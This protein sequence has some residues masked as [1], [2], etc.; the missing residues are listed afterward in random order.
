MW[1]NSSE[2]YGLVAII[3]HWLMALVIIGMFALGL[4]MVSLDYYDDWYHRGPFIHKSIGILLALVLSLRLV[5]RLNNGTPAAIDSHSTLVKRFS[6]SAHWLL[7]ILLFALVLSGY[8]ISTA[9]GKGISVFDWFEVPATIANIEGQADIAAEL[10]EWFAWILIII[11]SI[12]ALAALKHHFLD[13][14][15]TLKRMLVPTKK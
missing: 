4:W 13:K 2:G 7:Y 12:H 14:D 5:W 10:H 6:T 3:L 1:R 11:A 8:M 15:R 9:L